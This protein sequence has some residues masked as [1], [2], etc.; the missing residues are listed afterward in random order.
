[1]KIAKNDTVKVIAGDD[2]GKQGR[3]LR[4]VGDQR[5]VVENVKMVKRHRKQA[6]G[7][8]TGGIVEIE[9]PIHISNVRLVD[10]AGRGKG[11]D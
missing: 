6:Q 8:A 10:K 5:L 4:V 7:Q 3:V 11:K 9:A 1:M 2:R